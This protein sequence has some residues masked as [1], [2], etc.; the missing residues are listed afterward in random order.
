MPRIHHVKSARRRYKMV[1]KLDA[2]GDP[3]RTPVL[4]RDGTQKAT[5]KG[6]PVFRTATVQDR[7]QPLDPERCGKCG[8]TIEPGDPYKWTEI[9][10]QYGGR[11][12]VR[13][14]TC[15]TWRPSELSTSKMAG[16]YAAQEAVRE[17]AEEYRESAQAIEDGFGHPTYQ[18][19][20]LNER[21]DELDG[22]AD[23]VEGV[24]FD[25]WDPDPD[26]ERWEDED[27]DSAE[28]DHWDEMWSRLDDVA[29]E[30]PV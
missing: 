20:E 30:C 24:D 7:S 29:G 23:D 15:P 9:K 14:S 11:R 2:N 16:I 21:A 13:C 1:P 22:W 12:L 3:V 25:E 17:V 19:D 26:D 27:M 5:R 10:M 6:K 18:S 28:S 8:T 4:R